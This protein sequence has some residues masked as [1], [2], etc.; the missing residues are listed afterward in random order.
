MLWQTTNAQEVKDIAFTHLI[1]VVDIIALNYPNMLNKVFGHYYSFLTLKKKIFIL[2][3]L[4][5][6]LMVKLIYI[7]CLVN[8]QHRQK[9][10]YKDIAS[11]KM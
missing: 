10:R 8:K 2:F 6:I 5:F 4:L 1:V 3:L 7:L 11:D 9:K